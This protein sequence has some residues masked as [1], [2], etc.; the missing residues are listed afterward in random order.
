[1]VILITPS[2]NTP[3]PGPYILCTIFDLVLVAFHGLSSAGYT[4]N[5][6]SDPIERIADIGY[7]YN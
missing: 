6:V 5:I 3:S 1:M 4:V 7:M 2:D